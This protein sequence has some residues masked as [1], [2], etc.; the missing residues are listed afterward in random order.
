MKLERRIKK[1]EE[2]FVQTDIDPKLD[3]ELKEWFKS[4][5]EYYPFRQPECNNGV[6]LPEHLSQA[7]QCRIDHRIREK[8][9]NYDLCG[10]AE[11]GESLHP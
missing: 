8:N 9:L 7:F 10:L 6:V 5:P 2:L 11:I 3:A 4:P 1:L